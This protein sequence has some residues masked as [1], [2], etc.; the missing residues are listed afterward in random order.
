[1]AVPDFQSLMLPSLRALS[2]GAET[3]IADVRARV[4]ANENISAEDLR[5]MVPSGR[6]T[7]FTNRVSWA[8][9]YMERAGFAGA[10]S[11]RRLSVDGRR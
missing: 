11:P 10:S 5:E 2:G 9:L 4:A 1:M 6:K 7:V 3:P 8:L